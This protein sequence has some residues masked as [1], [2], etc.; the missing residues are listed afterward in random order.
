MSERERERER[1][2]KRAR[3]REGGKDERDLTFSVSVHLKA[4][5]SAARARAV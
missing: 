4:L 1:E 2:G 5:E 3:G